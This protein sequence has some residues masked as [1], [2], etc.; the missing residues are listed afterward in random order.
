MIRSLVLFGATGD[1]AERF[2]LPALAELRDANLL[3]DDFRV[4]G[5]GRTN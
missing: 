3:P 2:L 4:V 5:A 1:L